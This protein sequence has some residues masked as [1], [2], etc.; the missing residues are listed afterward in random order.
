MSW[1]SVVTELLKATLAG[2]D[3]DL[4]IESS[5]ACS[6]M[7]LSMASLLYIYSIKKSIH[8]SFISNDR[9]KY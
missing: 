5:S 4:Q 2:W 9:H 1:L 7:R 8:G 3:V 6:D